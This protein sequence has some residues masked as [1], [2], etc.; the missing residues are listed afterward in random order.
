MNRLLHSGTTLALK[1]SKN[2]ETKYNL[3]KNGYH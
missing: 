2:N 1:V 3:E